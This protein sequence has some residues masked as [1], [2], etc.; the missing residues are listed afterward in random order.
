M[1]LLENH[2]M[3]VLVVM[4]YM[5]KEGFTQGGQLVSDDL[6]LYEISPGK[7]FVKG[8][9]V[10][11]INTTYLDAPKPRTTKIRKTRYYF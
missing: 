11:T 8:Y 7:V 5:Q 6:A 10:E 4:E 9:E 1:F 3:M 2:W